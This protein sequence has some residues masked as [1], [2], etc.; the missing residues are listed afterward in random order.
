MD[1]LVAAMDPKLLCSSLSLLLVK[2]IKAICEFNVKYDQKL[3]IT[4]SLHVR[5]DGERVLTCLLDETTIKGQQEA[6]P[7]E[8]AA[9]PLALP[10]MGFPFPSL[11][12]QPNA[13][14]QPQPMATFLSPI[15]T[16]A[17]LPP[18]AAVLASERSDKALPS[19]SA[20]QVSQIDFT[21]YYLH[22]KCH[23]FTVGICNICNG[24][25]HAC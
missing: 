25:Q 4:G 17:P 11:Q 20:A 2:T 12:L 21:K 18:Q 6:K 24:V 16:M 5:S 3:E 1:L 19:P 14:Q 7:A 22:S 13:S 8:M 10:N 15:Q 23:V 9:P